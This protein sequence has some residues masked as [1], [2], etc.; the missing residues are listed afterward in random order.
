MKKIF[1]YISLSV[2]FLNLIGVALIEFFPNLWT[3]QYSLKYKLPVASFYVIFFIFLFILFY[4]ILYFLFGCNKRFSDH[5]HGRRVLISNDS[6]V[7]QLTFL[8]F[9]AILMALFFVFYLDG[10]SVLKGDIGRGVYR[11]IDF[12]LGPIPTIL[13]SY[14]APV[15]FFLMCL[16]FFSSSAKKYVFPIFVIGVGSSVTLALSNGFKASVIWLIVPTITFYFFAR[17]KPFSKVSLFFF[18]F[19]MFLLIVLS[20]IVL[21]GEGWLLSI[22]TVMERMSARTAIALVGISHNVPLTG[23]F[24]E[25]SKTLSYFLGGTFVKVFLASSPEEI[26]KYAFSWK[27]T[28]LSGYSVDAISEGGHTM[29]S[30]VVGGGIYSGGVIGVIIF[31]LIFSFTIFFLDLY[32]EKFAL[33][34]KF[35]SLFFVNFYFWLAP[36]GLLNGGDLTSLFNVNDFLFFIMAIFFAS[37]YKSSIWKLRLP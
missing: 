28:M 22:I 12:G 32:S 21:S 15:V 14:F 3:L 9:L 29:T 36:F 30:T 8:V 26:A 34:G 33:E 18:G 25:W 37:V 35:F 13:R 2:L 7:I 24:Y 5:C 11:R 23:D 16:V 27:A 1:F 31:A 6:A 4:F 20:K 19:S 17:G 10:I